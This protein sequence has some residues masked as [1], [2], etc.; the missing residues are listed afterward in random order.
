MSIYLD[1]AS[2]TFPKPEV[3]PQ[4]VVDYMTR[5]GANVGRGSYGEAYRVESMVYETR[6]LIAGLFDASDCRNV[7]FTRNVTEG[8]NALI[9]GYLHAGDHVIVSSMEHNAVM[10]PLV[11]VG[12]WGVSFTRAPCDGTGALILDELEGC[13]RPNTVAVIM[14]HASNV[15][16]TVMPAA[17]VGVFCH[18][19]GLRFFLDTAQSAGVIPVDMG[20][21]GVDAVAFTG[22]KALL[23]PQGIGGLVLAEDLVGQLEPL[24]TGGTGSMSHR[25]ETPSFMPDRMEAGTPNLPGIAGLHASL[26]WLRTW[27]IDSV[28][29]HELALVGRFLEGVRALEAKGL[30]RLVGRHDCE[31]RVGVVSVATPQADA[32]EVAGLMEER[33]GILTRVGLHCAPSAHRTCGTYPAGT[34]RFSF[35]FANDED[36]V[37][38]ALAALEACCRDQGR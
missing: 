7:A 33:F 8:L 27:G 12:R 37:D 22:H 26:G 11:Q 5:M 21:M 23:G 4:A 6:E 2:T 35:G 13:L 32:A 17:E 31:G 10:R 18:A 34:I 36:D 30:V 9:K 38:V 20:S 16:G 14:L 29:G 24:V 19:H 15:T 28:R 3:V 25:E 1:N